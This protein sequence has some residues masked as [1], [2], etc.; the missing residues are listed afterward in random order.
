MMISAIKTTK[1]TGMETP[2]TTVVK[3]SLTGP[4]IL[5]DR[6]QNRKMQIFIA[7]IAI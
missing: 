7:Y 6:I 4:F 2:V 1:S 3:K 5:P